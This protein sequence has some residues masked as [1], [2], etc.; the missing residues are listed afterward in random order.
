MCISTNKGQ[1]WAIDF[2]I[3][4]VM[5]FIALFVFYQYYSNTSTMDVGELQT[6]RRDAQAISNSLLS[7]GYPENWND[8]EVE[9][10]GIVDEGYRLNE[11]KLT[12]LTAMDYPTTKSILNTRYDYYFYFLDTNEQTAN[13]S[14]YG[15]PGVNMTNVEEI[16]DP[17]KIVTLSRFVLYNNKIERMVIYVWD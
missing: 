12:S 4:T 17:D 1:T 8:T 15:K 6:I 14:T 2:L 13:I 3:G 5:F 16:E 7:E 9:R 11:S 10:I